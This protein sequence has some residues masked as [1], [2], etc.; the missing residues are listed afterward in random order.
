MVSWRQMDLIAI[1][2]YV[3]V[4]VLIAKCGVTYRVLWEMTTFVKLVLQLAGDQMH[5][6]H[7][8]IHFGMEVAALVETHAALSTSLRG[9]ARS[10][11]SQLMMT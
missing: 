2:T 8:M 1:D 7:T 6:L 9:F 5:F 10:C 4:Q 11:L 3:L